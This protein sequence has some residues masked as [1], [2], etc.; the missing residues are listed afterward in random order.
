MLKHIVRNIQKFLVIF[1]TAEIGMEMEKENDKQN[2]PTKVEQ[3]IIN[4]QWKRLLNPYT[5]M[6]I[7][8]E[9]Y[10]EDAEDEE[11]QDDDSIEDDMSKD[12]DEAVIKANV[13]IIEISSTSDTDIDVDHDYLNCNEYTFPASDES[14][15][16][17]TAIF[18]DIDN[19]NAT[20]VDTKQHA[21]LISAEK[22]L[23]SIGT[24]HRVK[25]GMECDG[26]C[27]QTI[28]INF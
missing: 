18:P 20:T 21:S 11:S 25:L 9:E 12:N 15:K 13:V 14:P 26:H 3:E 17:D 16:A 27:W 7:I 10:N 28:V 2:Y 23:L 24:N 1:S 22:Y 8:T 19:A 4:A 5:H 6:Q